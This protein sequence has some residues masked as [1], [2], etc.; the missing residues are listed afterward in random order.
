MSIVTDKSSV[1]VGVAGGDYGIALGLFLSIP[2]TFE[3][4]SD[5]FSLQVG[6]R[7]LTCGTFG[8]V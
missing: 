5:S 3:L 4:V 1:I 6:V 2:D 7:K 8:K